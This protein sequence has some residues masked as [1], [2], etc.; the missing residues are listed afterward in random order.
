MVGRRADPTPLL[1]ACHANAVAL[2]KRNL[3][4]AGILAATPGARSERRGYTAIF[5]RDAAICA[6]GMALSRDHELERAAVAGLHTLA[7]HQAANGQIPKFV[8]PHRREADFWYVGCIDS[9]LWWL[10]A[11]A[12]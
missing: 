11:V 12:F 3:T 10:I 1:A 7:R 9:T 5:G 8:D 4:A 6:I 2:L